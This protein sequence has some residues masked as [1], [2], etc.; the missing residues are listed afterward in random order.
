MDQTTLLYFM[1][2]V[3]TVSA[4]AL[5]IQMILVVQVYK[6]T[7]T[8]TG[9]AMAM[10]PK[11]EGLLDSSKAAVD[12]GRATVAEIRQKSNLILDSGQRQMQQVEALLADATERTNRQLA[13]AEAV[14][15]DT[16]SR[17]EGTVEMVHRGV[18]K[19]LRGISGVAAGISAAIQY[20]MS[21]R[22]NPENATLDE[23]M[24]I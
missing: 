19:P 9:R 23:E 21:R 17:V 3:F 24:F 6:A 1:A 16:L 11:V 18:L 7:M 10:L 2:G 15:Q 14:V 4:V 12:E 13:Y 5:V 20:L 8:V 22:P